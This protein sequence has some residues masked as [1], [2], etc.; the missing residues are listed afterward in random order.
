LGFFEG[1]WFGFPAYL[2]YRTIPQEAFVTGGSVQFL[3]YAG[4]PFPV[5]P[6]RMFIYGSTNGQNWSLLGEVVVSSFPQYFSLP[7]NNGDP[8]HFLEFVAE[9]DAIIDD[10]QITIEYVLPNP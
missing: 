6:G 1:F 5:Q 8:V 9:H 10:L 7:I 2:G 3:H 4:L